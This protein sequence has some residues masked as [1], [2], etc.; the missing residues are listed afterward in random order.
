MAKGIGQYVHCGW[1]PHT[2]T[3]QGCGGIRVLDSIWADTV[4]MA[5][6]QSGSAAVL[7]GSGAAAR[8]GI[9]TRSVVDYRTMSL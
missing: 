5:P 8:S 9:A 1:L 3:Q 6:T 4:G 7:F 2:N